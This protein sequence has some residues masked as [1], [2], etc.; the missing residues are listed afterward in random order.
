MAA[1]LGNIFICNLCNKGNIFIC[2]LCSRGKRLRESQ[3]DC[4]EQ[5]KKASKKMIEAS[6]FK[7]TLLHT[8]DAV[9]VNIATVD[10]S[11]LDPLNI[12]SVIKK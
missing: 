3:N 8:G 9:V 7:F 2:N 4:Y 6:N 12:I 5:Q 1:Y 11:S 10:R